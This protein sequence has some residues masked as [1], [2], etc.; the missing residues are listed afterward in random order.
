[1][2][3]QEQQQSDLTM[4]YI[5]RR[6][7][8]KKRA[9]SN[10]NKKVLDGLK[11]LSRCAQSKIYAHDEQQVEKIMLEIKQAVADLDR[12]FTEAGGEGRK[13]VEL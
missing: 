4:D 13:W 7:A 6:A 2:T 11:Q 10:L 1:M 8:F 3:E 9:E 5:E 12:T